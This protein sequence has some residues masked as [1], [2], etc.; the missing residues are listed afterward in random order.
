[1]S[2]YFSEG[3]HKS[4]DAV[5]DRFIDIDFDP[6]GQRS[7]MVNLIIKAAL[8]PSYR[9]EF[10]AIL[11]NAV[12]AAALINTAFLVAAVAISTLSLSAVLLTAGLWYAREFLRENI[13]RTVVGSGILATHKMDVNSRPFQLQDL[14]LPTPIFWRDAKGAASS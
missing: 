5:V 10:R 14:F 6:N 3:I 12:T 11:F 4:F 2:T 13:A 7:D 1:M 9:Y 8:Q